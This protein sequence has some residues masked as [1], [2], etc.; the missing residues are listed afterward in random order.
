MA[1]PPEFEGGA[2]HPK[3]DQTRHWKLSRGYTMRKDL[4]PNK[5]GFAWQYT[6][7][8]SKR[9]GEYGFLQL[10]EAPEAMRKHD[11]RAFYDKYGRNVSQENPFIL[12]LYNQ[13]KPGGEISSKGIMTEAL[14]H[15]IRHHAEERGAKSFTLQACGSHPPREE[16]SLDEPGEQAEREAGMRRL[17]ELYSSKYGFQPLS[18]DPKRHA[19]Y[20]AEQ[21]VGMHVP[22]DVAVEASA[23]AEAARL[24][25]ERAAV[26]A[27]RRARQAKAR[28]ER[29]LIQAILAQQRAA[30]EAEAAAAEAAAKAAAAKAE[31]KTRV[32]ADARHIRWD[33][34][35]LPHA[36]GHLRWDDDDRAHMVDDSPEDASEARHTF[37]DT[38]GDEIGAGIEATCPFHSQ[39]THARLNGSGLYGGS[40]SK[41]RARTSDEKSWVLARG[42][43][44]RYSTNKDDH[45]YTV[46]HPDRDDSGII[47]MTDS[48][49]TVHIQ[50]VYNNFRPGGVPSSRG[51]MQEALQLALRHQLSR[52]SITY[53][54]LEAA[55]SYP[56]VR[57]DAPI[58]EKR[59]GLRRLVRLYHSRFG[60]VP[61]DNDALE[62]DIHNLW[63][64]MHA[65]AQDIQAKLDDPAVHGAGMYTE[66]TC[67]FHAQHLGG[68]FFSDAFNAVRNA[69][70]NV[71][72]TVADTANKA[73][74]TVSGA[75]NT[76]KNAVVEGATRAVNAVR[77][78][79]TGMPPNAQAT[80]DQY[81]LWTVT[82]LVVRRD[83]VQ[84][85]LS[86][87]MNLVSLGAWNR[88]R[89]QY[90]FDDVFHLGLLID[91]EAP[92]RSAR[93][94]VLAEKNEVINLGTPKPVQERTQELRI[95]PPRPPVT[96][97][98]FWAK[99]AAAKGPSFYL[100]DAFHNNCQDFVLGLLHANGAATD[101]AEKFVKQRLEQVIAQQP[102]W[103]GKVAN[104]VTNLGARVDRIKQ[105][106]TLWRLPNGF[107]M[108]HKKQHGDMHT[109]LVHH[110]ARRGNGYI[111]IMRSLARDTTG[112][113]GRMFPDTSATEAHIKGF[114]NQFEP[115]PGAPSARGIMQH[116]MRH[117]LKHQM[118]DGVRA[119]T[120]QASGEYPARV[121]PPEPRREDYPTEDAWLKYLVGDL[122]KQHF[123]AD[124]EAEA[125]RDAMIAQQEAEAVRNMIEGQRRLVNLYT[126]RFGFQPI[127][128]D[129]LED[130]IHMQ[131]VPMRTTAS[132]LARAYDAEEAADAGA[133]E[134]VPAAGDKRRREDPEPD[135]FS[136]AHGAGLEAVCPFHHTRWHSL[137]GGSAK[138]AFVAKMAGM[139]QIDLGKLDT[140]WWGDPPQPGKPNKWDKYLA[141]AAAPAPAAAAAAPAPAPAAPR[142]IPFSR[143]S[144]QPAWIR[145]RKLMEDK[146]SMRG[147]GISEDAPEPHA[148]LALPSATP[149]FTAHTM[150]LSRRVAAEMEEGPLP[151]AGYGT[152]SSG[153]F[154]SGKAGD[155]ERLAPKLKRN[156]AA[157][158]RENRLRPFY[159]INAPLAVPPVSGYARWAPVTGV[160]SSTH[161]HISATDAD[162]R[163]W[164][165]RT[166]MAAVPSA[167]RTQQLFRDPYG[168]LQAAYPQDEL[169]EDE[170]DEAPHGS[171]GGFRGGALDGADGNLAVNPGMSAAP[172][173]QSA[174]PADPSFVPR[175]D[176][177]SQ[178]EALKIVPG[179][180]SGNAVVAAQEAPPPAA[181]VV[182]LASDSEEEAPAAQPSPEVVEG[183]MAAAPLNPPAPAAAAG[184]APGAP[185]PLPPAAPLDALLAAP[186]GPAPPPGMAAPSAAALGLD[187]AGMAGTKRKRRPRT[188]GGKADR[189]NALVGRLMKEEGLSL[190]AASRKV[191][192]SGM[193]Y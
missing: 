46:T 135:S 116:A 1:D 98:D 50:G 17:T 4:V 5:K 97:G 63:V 96:L 43:R 51:I 60:F 141:P 91:L 52:R 54:T 128:P 193:D 190:A 28:R 179:N 109:Y 148:H 69:A 62:A 37:Y 70:T 27:A 174:D 191:K 73:V 84:K 64:P 134:A 154:P 9:P 35:D 14:H 86:T 56:P 38:D 47:S 143:G 105:G 68:G 99:A 163:A 188:P 76:A 120:L 33:D 165:A 146:R 45:A 83:P 160:S 7:G 77:G 19:Y 22:A 90:G 3:K 39:S 186:G 181:H 185:A 180:V 177:S 6:V 8:H 49:R 124:P 80:L 117:A 55:G 16:R 40:P 151:R 67:P 129:T 108:Q 85:A 25:A 166:Q 176:L 18:P 78:V 24:A 10:A 161:G 155:L 26:V 106:G 156:T 150:H 178:W 119:F 100:Y 36:V 2:L 164:M 127:D 104:A 79:R 11:V 131:I 110:P 30:A 12:G 15:A 149:R 102:S 59:E 23:A 107:T 157:H 29:P 32:P 189:R 103:L 66:D 72:Q 139:H 75:V 153:W 171:G 112:G 42:F 31:E 133:A 41:K 162:R 158:P 115:A 187:G 57:D 58:A 125:A 20:L 136:D 152:R 82:G 113:I 87:V 118:E 132:R 48:G 44:M 147:A 184:A 170:Y 65:R 130:D 94:R 175:E 192:E 169:P 138:S 88:A 101:E 145:Q 168:D 173:T 114:Y 74:H 182:D 92:D 81:A 144:T 137:E 142:P 61:E 93:A 172:L 111:H 167:A 122:M 13:F 159:D 89:A 71:G 140:H 126:Q 21:S 121:D 95:P 53:F 183:A 34:E 123:P